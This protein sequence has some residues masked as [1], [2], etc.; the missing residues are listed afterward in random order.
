M[1]LT[2][3]D[4]FRPGAKACLSPEHGNFQQNGSHECRRSVPSGSGRDW[5]LTFMWYGRLDRWTVTI[6]TSI[7]FRPQVECIPSRV[8][9]CLNHSYG[10][11]RVFESLELE[12]S[13]HQT[14]IDFRRSSDIRSIQPCILYSVLH[15]R[16]IYPKPMIFVCFRQ[17]FEIPCPTFSNTLWKTIWKQVD[18]FHRCEIKINWNR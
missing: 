5:N 18:G 16:V 9:N 10:D 1:A 4:V 11:K 2:I 8:E 14:F 15:G 17:A 7:P 13:T 12:I 3:S 6:E